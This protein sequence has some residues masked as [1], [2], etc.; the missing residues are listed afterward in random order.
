M[1]DAACYREDIDQTYFF[2]GTRYARIKFTPGTS[3][4]KITVGPTTTTKNWHSLAK[5]GFGTVDAGFPGPGTQ[6][7]AY[8]F[9]GVNY[10][11]INVTDD[12]IIYNSARIDEHWPA[13][14]KAGFDSVDTALAVPK[15][16]N[17]ETYFFKSDHYAKIKVVA[18]HLDTVIWG[19]KPIEECWKTLDWI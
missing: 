11:R 15:R 12:Q 13:L 2:G 18:G 16:G 6:D 3:F 1:V 14:V 4:E 7:E 10:A 8:V 17:G 19:P 5:V 9:R